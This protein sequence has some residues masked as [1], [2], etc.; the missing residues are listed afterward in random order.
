MN[1]NEIGRKLDV[2]ASILKLAHSDDIQRART[3]IRSDPAKAAIL[4]K[5]STWVAG[6]ELTKAVGRDV[7]KSERSIRMSVAELLQL[8]VLE[9]RGAGPSTEYRTTGLI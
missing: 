3:A 9:K 7:K 1:E 2:I 4:D 5:S 6:G 8:G